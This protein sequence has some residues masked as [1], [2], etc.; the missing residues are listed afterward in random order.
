LKIDFSDFAK[1]SN[2]REGIALY[3]ALES[4]RL[5]QLQRLDW[6]VSEEM[7][8]MNIFLLSLSKGLVNSV[9]TLSKLNIE[10]PV[11]ETGKLR[12]LVTLI[13]Q[14]PRLQQLMLE[15]SY[16]NAR[17]EDLDEL[18]RLMNS[19]I[20]LT[21]F[22]FHVPLTVE[23][24]IGLMPKLYRLRSLNYLSLYMVE[25]EVEAVAALISEVYR[26][27]QIRN[28]E[29]L[30]PRSDRAG[31]LFERCFGWEME[32]VDFESKTRLSLERNML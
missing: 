27:T 25:F 26:N 11:W 22:K 10:L 31:A 30:V 4:L 32:T 18:D 12:I 7:D 6:W 29:L 23:Q 28:I 15:V 17:A 24:V 5:H 21:H 2:T 3:R 1:L 14:F 13:L 20:A 19:D 16:W 9:N 8:G